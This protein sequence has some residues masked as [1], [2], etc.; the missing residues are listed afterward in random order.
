MTESQALLREY[1]EK[2]SE[3]AFRELVGRYVDMVFSTALRR[4]A[5][6]ATKSFLNSRRRFEPGR[7]HSHGPRVESVKRLLEKSHGSGASRRKSSRG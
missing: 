3:E 1:A 2:G 5:G 7:I 4:L 6:D